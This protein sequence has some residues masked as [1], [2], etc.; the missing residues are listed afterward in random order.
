[1]PSPSALQQ[2]ET[3]DEAQSR[4]ATPD[5]S[6]AEPEIQEQAEPETMTDSQH[7]HEIHYEREPAVPK[8][9]KKKQ[10]G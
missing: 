6:E 5:Y 10:S 4:D 1:M 3:A 9:Q 8:K 2:K 7:L